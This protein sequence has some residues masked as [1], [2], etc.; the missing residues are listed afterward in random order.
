MTLEFE[1]GLFFGFNKVV[2]R[3]ILGW[4]INQG[5]DDAN[6]QVGGYEI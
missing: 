5:P 3:W 4:E 2:I 1:S 6:K